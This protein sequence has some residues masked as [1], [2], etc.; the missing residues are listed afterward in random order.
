MAIGVRVDKKREKEL[1]DTAITSPHGANLI[2]TKSRAATLLARPSIRLGDGTAR[3][4]RAGH[5][6]DTEAVEETV[7]KAAPPRKGGRG[8]TEPEG[9]GE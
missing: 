2:V 4:Y 9:G 8:N 7:S 6:Q 5:D 3:V 1:K